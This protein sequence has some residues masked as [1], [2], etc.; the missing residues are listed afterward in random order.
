VVMDSAK[1]LLIDTCGEGAGVALCRGGEVLRSEEL[2][3]RGASAGVV[4]SMRRLLEMQE[5]KVAEL[6]CVGVVNGPG[7]F[8]GVRA[9]VAAAKGLSEAA[10]LRLASVSR[11]AVLCDAVE[12]REGFAALRA[13]RGELYVR[14]AA[15]GREWMVTQEEFL[16]QAGEA[17]VVV[18]E[19]NVAEMLQELRPR[20][21]ELR[22]SDALGLVLQ[23]LR[24]GGADV[25][26]LDANYVRSEG[27]I[28]KKAGTAR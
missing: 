7:S 3:E 6:D 20:V 8:T 28:Y 12:I 18:S 1:I 13:G 9:G 23:S 14:D 19:Q 25:A 10:G 2:P 15:S 27:D 4:A 5:W 11:L 22:V 26:L 16:T 21:H 17:K 24:D